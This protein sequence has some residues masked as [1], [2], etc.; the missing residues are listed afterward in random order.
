MLMTL[1][2]VRSPN[3]ESV[4][5]R[6]YGAPETL[7]VE[8]ISRPAVGSDQVLVRV[9]AASLNPTDHVEMRGLARLQIGWRRPRQHVTG[10]STS[11]ASSK[12]SVR[13]SPIWRPETPCAESV[14]NGGGRS[15]RALRRAV[16]PGGVVVLNCSHDLSLIVA[17]FAARLVFRR[18]ARQPRSSRSGGSL[19]SRRT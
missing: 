6:R 3:D 13:T 12:L 2:D 9:R 15:L 1:Q 18:R 7:E 17:G 5:Q 19:L 11:P 4:V 10:A 14:D 8:E 16:A